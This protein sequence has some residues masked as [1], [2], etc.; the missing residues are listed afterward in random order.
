[1]TTKGELIRGILFPK[2][3]AFRF[4]QDL[5]RVVMLFMAFGLSGMIYSFYTWIH[6][7]ATAREI[8]LN[9]LDII[10]FVV[11]PFLPVAVT[12]SQSFAR[13]RLK[14]QRIF[15]LNSKHITQ[16]GG[17]SIVCFDKVNHYF[18]KISLNSTF[19]V[20]HH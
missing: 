16:C 19:V 18:I 9:S 20:T 14:K 12:A 6:N 15:C 17:I 2:P 7:G 11:P 4:Y 10:T 13:N 5:I 8:I 3:M 1:M